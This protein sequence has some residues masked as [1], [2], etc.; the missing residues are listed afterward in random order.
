MYLGKVYRSTAIYGG[1]TKSNLYILEELYYSI[2]ILGEIT[3]SL[4]FSTDH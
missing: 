2:T 1:A 3:K 4:L